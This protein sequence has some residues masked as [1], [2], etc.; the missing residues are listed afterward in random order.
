MLESGNP[1]IRT[2]NHFVD[3]GTILIDP[4]TMLDGDAELVIKRFK[5]IIG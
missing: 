1:S 4:R 5:E 2:R 3:N